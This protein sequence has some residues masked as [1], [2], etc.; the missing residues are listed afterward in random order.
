MIE[1]PKN[2]TVDNIEEPIEAS[3]EPTINFTR[4]NSYQ[5]EMYCT[6]TKVYL[7]PHYLE[8]SMLFNGKC[9]G[10]DEVAS[11][12]RKMIAGYEIVLKDGNKILLSNV[13]GKMRAGITEVL[14]YHTKK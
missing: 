11:Y 1:L 2:F 14:D 3:F 13:F 12:G 8:E 6:A 4:I 7:T 10:Y 9:F 5:G